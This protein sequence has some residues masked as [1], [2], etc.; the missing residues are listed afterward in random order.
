MKK[1][2]SR[3]EVKNLGY[4]LIFF[5]RGIYVILSYFYFA[6][7]L[8]KCGFFISNINGDKRIMIDYPYCQ[9]K[10]RFHCERKEKKN[11]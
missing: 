8:Q 4:D 1:V 6:L 10:N 9:R 2:F 7:R 5:W 11:I 3:I